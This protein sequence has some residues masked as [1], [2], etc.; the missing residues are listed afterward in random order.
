[1]STH[2]ASLAVGYAALVAYVGQ[3]AWLLASPT[4]P[5]LPGGTPLNAL[6]PVWTVVVAGGAGAAAHV[7][8]RLPRRPPS[9]P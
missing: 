5:L 2:L 4:P 8:G 1:M 9:Q 3:Q 6:D 7:L